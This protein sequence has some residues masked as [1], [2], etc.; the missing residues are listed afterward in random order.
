MCAWAARSPS[1]AAE[2]FPEGVIGGTRVALALA[3]DHEDVPAPADFSLLPG[4]CAG[5]HA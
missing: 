3:F 4:L 5:R 2:C 1:L